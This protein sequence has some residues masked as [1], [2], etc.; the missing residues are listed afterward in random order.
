MTPA[1]NLAL[2]FFIYTFFANLIPTSVATDP[3]N[4]TQSYIEHVFCQPT[5]TWIGPV[6]PPD[7]YEQ[8]NQLLDIFKQDQPETQDK[9]GPPYEFLPVGLDPHPEHLP[10]VRTPWKLSYGM[11]PFQL[12]MTSSGNP[13]GGFR[14]PCQ[15]AATC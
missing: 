3:T 8:C 7:I 9:D 13:L 10:L 4:A 5:D 12:G 14:F 11:S 6:W 2:S 1:T 15:C